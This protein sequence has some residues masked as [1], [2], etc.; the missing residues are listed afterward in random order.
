MNITR[1]ASVVAHLGQ[2]GRDAEHDRRMRVVPAR[3]ASCPAIFDANGR[4]AGSLDRQRVHVGADRDRRPGLAAFEHARRCPVLPMPVRHGMPSR[5]R[6]ACTRC[7]G[8][9]LLERELRMLVDRAPQR[10]QLVGPAIGCLRMRRSWSSSSSSCHCSEQ[11]RTSPARP[12]NHRDPARSDRIRVSDKRLQAAPRERRERSRLLVDARQ[13]AGRRDPEPRRLRL[14]RARPGA[15]ARRSVRRLAAQLHA[16]S[17]TPTVGVVRVPWND[18][19]YLKRVLDVGAEAVLIPSIDT[20][21]EAR[22]AVAACLLPAARAPR[23]GVEL[24]ARVELRHGARLRRDL[25]RQPADRVPDRIREGGREHRRDPRGRRHRPD[26]HRAVRSVGHGRADGQSQASGGRAADRSRRGAHPGGG[27][28]DG[29][30]SASGL[31][32]RRTCSRAATSS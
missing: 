6:N 10:D 23:H 30:R 5:G 32:V 16:M 28:S 21:D 4:P 7:R 3:S 1:P 26:V 18:H 20:A 13:S 25:R 14:P 22:A 24:G 11:S 19:V 8:F 17:A 12:S 31:H 2:H 15:W 27:P 29:H 9:V